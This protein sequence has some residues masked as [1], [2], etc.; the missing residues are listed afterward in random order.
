MWHLAVWLKRVNKEYLKLLVVYSN[1]GE[2]FT[3]I[4][5]EKQIFLNG[6]ESQT[7]KIRT[8]IT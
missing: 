3:Q 6:C 7:V 5:L 2:I 1:L 8:N 4:Y